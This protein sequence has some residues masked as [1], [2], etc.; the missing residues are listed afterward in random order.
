[1]AGMATKAWSRPQDWV[2]LAAGVVAALSPIWLTTSTAM[3]WTLI[4]LGVL[5]A[6]DGLWSLARPS[7]P[8]SEGLQIV[9]GALLF[10][11]PWVLG[12]TSM[13]TSWWTWVLGAVTV[14]AGA[15]ALPMAT[16]SHRH[17]AVTH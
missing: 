12:A 16:S 7:V 17:T 2:E 4:V 5:I 14:V 8:Y 15:L 9:L 13:T 11:S 3:M 6:L 1:M 10:I